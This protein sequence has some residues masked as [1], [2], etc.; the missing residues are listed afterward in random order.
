MP[1]D[2]SISV[3]AV[4][5]DD[6]DTSRPQPRY[7][8]SASV[9]C[10]WMPR[11]QKNEVRLDSFPGQEF[12]LL[13]QLFQRESHRQD[14]DH[15]HRQVRH[16]RNDRLLLSMHQFTISGRWAMGNISS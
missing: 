11:T 3:V 13:M 5:D 14:D 6:D 16:T 4:D 9:S 2:T 10:G 7:E 1:S 8:I 12:V 15:R